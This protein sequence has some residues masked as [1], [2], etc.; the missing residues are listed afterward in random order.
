M[1]FF[2]HCRAQQRHLFIYLLA[3]ALQV[4]HVHLES[5]NFSGEEA[6]MQT[7]G[8]GEEEFSQKCKSIWTLSQGYWLVTRAMS[9]LCG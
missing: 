6:A 3:D 9:S 5:A 2:S 1:L 4:T 7:P 8:S